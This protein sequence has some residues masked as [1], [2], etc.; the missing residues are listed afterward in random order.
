MFS[1]EEIVKQKNSSLLVNKNG[2]V[3]VYIPKTISRDSMFLRKYGSK[4]NVALTADGSLLIRPTE[5]IIQ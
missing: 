5:T 1:T 4:A 3:Y 2:S